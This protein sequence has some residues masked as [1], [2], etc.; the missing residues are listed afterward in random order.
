VSHHST[1]PLRNCRVVAL[2]ALISALILPSAIVS[3]QSDFLETPISALEFKVGS[4]FQLQSFSGGM[5]SWKHL[6]N[7]S[8]GYRVGISPVVY[9]STGSLDNEYDRLREQKEYKLDILAQFLRFG[10]LGKRARSFWGVGPVI[11]Y[12][13]RDQK[14]TREGP[15]GVLT[16]NRIIAR[17]WSAGIAGTIGVE[18]YFLDKMSLSGEYGLKLEYESFNTSRNGEEGEGIRF[19]P[20]NATLGLSFYF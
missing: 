18:Y 2:L 16:S 8:R 12:S 9:H 13:Y 19:G 11:G 20:Q 3:A 7:E 17:E 15:E 5:I 14:E 4:N 6:S 10:K 1:S